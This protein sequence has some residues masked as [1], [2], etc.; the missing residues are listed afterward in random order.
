VS[1]PRAGS[2]EGRDLGALGGDG[3]RVGL[4]YDVHRLEVG[5]KLWLGG[6]ELPQIDGEKGLEGHSDADV[7]LHAI[8]D[9][10]LGAA[11]LG[12]IGRLYPP[13]DPAYK[14]IASIEL[15]RDVLGRLHGA[16]FVVKNVDATLVA[17]A[18]KIAPHV[19]KMREKVA[20]ALQIHTGAVSIKATTCEGLGWIGAGGGMAALAVAALA[21]RPG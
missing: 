15:V 2:E 18:P 13:D 19:E 3:I 17:E 1:G 6:V 5:R 8:C 21:K 11:A 16:G 12:D 9:A 7:L 14:D 10:L 20:E 4:G